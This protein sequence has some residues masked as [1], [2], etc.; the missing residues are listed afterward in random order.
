M[1]INKAR[2]IIWL[3]SR[4]K[5]SVKKADKIYR[6]G[7]ASFTKDPKAKTVLRINTIHLNGIRVNISYQ[8]F[9]LFTED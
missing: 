4:R 2:N 6:D 7:V 9:Q 3:I 8:Y 5:Q 1:P